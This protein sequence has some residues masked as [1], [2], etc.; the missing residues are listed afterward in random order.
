MSD[1]HNLP[2]IWSIYYETTVSDKKHIKNLFGGISGFWRNYYLK[3]K[4]QE[5]N[6]VFNSRFG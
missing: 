6:F 1:R 2:H 5:I 4:I 3:F